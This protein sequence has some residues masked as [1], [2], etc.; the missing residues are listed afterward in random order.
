[1]WDCRAWGSARHIV[2]PSADSE[3]ANP[4][5]GCTFWPANTQLSFSSGGGEF[6]VWSSTGLI[7]GFDVS[8]GRRLGSWMCGD[9]SPRDEARQPA[10]QYPVLDLAIAASGLYVCAVGGRSERQRQRVAATGSAEKQNG[11]GVPA[12]LWCTTVGADG[13]VRPNMH[14]HQGIAARGQLSDSIL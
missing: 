9:A 8:D 7:S 11:W 13:T 4:L 6:L 1:M 10:Q 14:C 2:T 12:Q 3:D 5:F